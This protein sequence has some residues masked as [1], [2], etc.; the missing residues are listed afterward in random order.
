MVESH[1][2]DP[3]ILN[4]DLKAIQANLR[5]HLHSLIMFGRK[6]NWSKSKNEPKRKVHVLGA[7]MLT[8]V[9]FYCFCCFSLVFLSLLKHEWVY[10]FTSGCCSK[11][12]IS[13]PCKCTKYKCLKNKNIKFWSWKVEVF[14]SWRRDE[15]W[16]CKK[17]EKNKL[18]SSL[19]E[20]L[21]VLVLIKFWRDFFFQIWN[22]KRVINFLKAKE[23]KNKEI[24][25][26]CCIV[27][28][29]NRVTNILCLCSSIVCVLRS[30][31]IKEPWEKWENKIK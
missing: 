6:F 13:S 9:F 16:I 3:R 2:L 4:W 27:I 12:H 7:K 26:T 28:I 24:P 30:K 29:K 19:L 22:L 23:A 31:T 14:I 17:Y 1:K 15:V 21:V 20:T 5:W 8:R 25:M 10:R 18:N 11:E